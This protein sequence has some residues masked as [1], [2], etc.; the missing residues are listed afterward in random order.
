MARLEF[1]CRKCGKVTPAEQYKISRFCF[2]CGT[3]LNI[4][5]QPKYWLFQFNPSIYNW[6]ERI[7]EAK[8]PEQWLVSQ[9]VKLISKGD[10]VAIW[11]SGQKAGIYALGTILTNPAKNPLTP[12][13][14]KYFLNKCDTG[15]FQER[16]SAYVEYFKIYLEK[17]LLQEECNKDCILSG[18]QVIKNP[19]G[20]NFRLTDAQWDRILELTNTKLTN[21]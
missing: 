15:K 5:P 3:L 12:S 16:S 19:Q 7:K 17:P 4:R 20:T 8:E 10:F 21:G 1:E 13:Q 2:S 9:H 6:F 11:S 18:M 14:E